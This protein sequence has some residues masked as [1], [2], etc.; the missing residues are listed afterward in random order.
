MYTPH[1]KGW[2]CDKS[3]EITKSLFIPTGILNVYPSNSWFTH[4]SGRV[5]DENLKYYNSQSDNL[6][7][8][9]RKINQKLR[10]L[11]VRIFP[12][13]RQKKILKRWIGTSRWMYNQAISV[14]KYA[15]FL[16]ENDMI[17]I[18]M[19][20]GSLYNKQFP[21][22]MD[23]PSHCKSNAIRDVYKARKTCFSLLKNKK[24]K[25]FKLSFKRKKDGGSIVI[26][27]SSIKKDGI[28]YIR[29][30]GNKNGGKSK[31]IKREPLK[32]RKG[33]I[34]GINLIKKG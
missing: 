19:G 13:K 33:N 4:F 27:K 20:K 17:N 24:I 12:S 7:I 29:T 16:T 8:K 25:K 9:K 15:S 21:W 18:L 1:S 2:W 30:L 22:L 28:I 23:T 6:E 5:T 10:S 26:P 31:G 34:K 3:N 14:L 11:K 32:M